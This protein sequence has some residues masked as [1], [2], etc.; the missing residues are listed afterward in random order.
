MRTT[1]LILALLTIS[2]SLR[3]QTGQVRGKVT[4]AGQALV[5]APVSLYRGLERVAYLQTDA[6]GEFDFGKVPAG[7][8]EVETEIGSIKVTEQ[9]CIEDRTAFILNMYDGPPCP[10]CPARQMVAN[11]SW[12]GEIPRADIELN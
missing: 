11:P 12:H 4:D 6:Q 2:C 5:D 3:A 7:C 1:I 10:C 8:Y 9:I